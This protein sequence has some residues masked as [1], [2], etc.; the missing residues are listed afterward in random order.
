MT[1]T[2]LGNAMCDIYCQTEK[3]PRHYDRMTKCCKNK[4]K[5]TQPNGDLR[6]LSLQ[7]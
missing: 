2:K 6:F 5:A 4:G 3:K 7:P 1:N